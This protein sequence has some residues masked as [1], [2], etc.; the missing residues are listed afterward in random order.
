MLRRSEI[1]ARPRM[2]TPR[3]Q[4]LEPRLLPSTDPSRFTDGQG[5]DPVYLS[6]FHHEELSGLSSR[7]EEDLKRRSAELTARRGPGYLGSPLS[8]A[9]Q[10]AAVLKDP[11]RSTEEKVTA[12]AK[13]LPPEIC[14]PV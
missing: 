11:D 14:E 7:F 8:G 12:I 2:P 10:L 3:W 6:A 4:G 5:G 9:D 13:T 1:A